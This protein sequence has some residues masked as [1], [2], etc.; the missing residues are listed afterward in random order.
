MTTQALKSYLENRAVNIE[1]LRTLKEKG[2]PLE[3]SEYIVSYV[4]RNIPVY[5]TFD[6]DINNILKSL[7][8]KNK[9]SV[10]AYHLLNYIIYIFINKTIH[11]AI[12]VTVHSRR[13]TLRAG[14]IDYALGIYT[15]KPTGLINSMRKAGNEAINDFTIKSNFV[16][17]HVEPIVRNNMKNSYSTSQLSKD[18]MPYLLAV[19]EVFVRRI[20]KS[21]I[22]NKGLLTADDI[23]TGIEN[24]N[25]LKIMLLDLFI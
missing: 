12:I 21:S 14:D 5:N 7:K 11:D 1:T 10:D 8:Y 2:L 6:K 23:L 20:L 17:L 15:D 13:H 16:R 18:S 4:D 25:N 9:L 3:I 22:K 19:M 24:N